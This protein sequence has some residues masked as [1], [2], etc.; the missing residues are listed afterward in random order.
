MKNCSLSAAG[1]RRSASPWTISSGVRTFAT[2]R[3][4][5]WRHSLSMPS[6]ESGSPIRAIRAYSGPESELAH[7]L[8][9]LVTPFSETAALKRSVVPT[10]QLTM[11]PP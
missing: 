1:Q 11:N 3:S 8:I 4:G 6:G 10:S 7:A 9:W 5:D 2:F